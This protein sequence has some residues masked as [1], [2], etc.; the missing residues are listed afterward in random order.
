MIS[1]LLFFIICCIFLYFLNLYLIKFNFCL[2]KISKSEKHKFLL[3]L[4]KKVPLSG[5]FYFLPI[6]LL[7]LN[8]DLLV[9]FICLFFFAIGLL[10][11][12]KIAS[13]PKLRLLIQFLLLVFFVYLN[14]DL[15]IDTRVDVLNILISNEFLRL[16][17]ISF[18]FLV[19]I[20]G[21]NFIDGVNNLASLNLLI[22]LIFIYLLINDAVVFEFKYTINLALISIFVFVLFN[23]FGKNFLGDGGVYG[24]SFLIGVMSIELSQLSDKVSPYFIANLL[25]YPAFENL[26]SIIR[27]ILSSKK[28]YIAD[29]H[30]LHQLLYSYLNKKK[31]IKQKY[32][33]SSFTGVSINIY[34]LIIYYIGYLNYHDTKYQLYL[35]FINIFCYSIF[36]FYLKNKLND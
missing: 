25:W 4:D 2:D 34:L 26:F 1:S 23:F 27:R 33:L 35:I 5:S 6:F 12:L 24:L 20:N 30:H 19:L 31:I 3:K 10:S 9:L 13:S 29:N 7:L 32:L 22:V 17:L 15:Q 28:N 36:Y 18:F 11:D 14:K 16:I 21:Y 8:T